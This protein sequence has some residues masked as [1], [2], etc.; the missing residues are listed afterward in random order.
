MFHQSV[1]KVHA[2]RW[3]LPADGLDD[4]IARATR[5]GYGSSNINTF[6]EACLVKPPRSIVVESRNVLLIV[7][8][9]YP[10]GMNGSRFPLVRC[11][12]KMLGIER[13]C[14]CPLIAPSAVKCGDTATQYWSKHV[15]MR[16]GG[17]C[18]DP[19]W[20]RSPPC[21]FPVFC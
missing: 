1:A 5:G 20:G 13:A 2:V 16:G 9:G 3:L 10:G 19:N 6:K 8:G 15:G 17:A 7:S 12:R 4:T 14:V 11:C 21:L 18:A